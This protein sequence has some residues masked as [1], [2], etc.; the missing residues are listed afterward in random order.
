MKS[1]FA[2]E[3]HT[4]TKLRGNYVAAPDDTEGANLQA[5]T[6]IRLMRGIDAIW[7]ALE[8]NSIPDWFDAWMCCPSTIINFDAIELASDVTFVPDNENILT[9][10][11]A[12]SQPATASMDA[13]VA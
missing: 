1:V 12:M 4:I 6:V 10:P 7:E 8:R 13:F 3:G 11:G 5:S 9:F 2:Y